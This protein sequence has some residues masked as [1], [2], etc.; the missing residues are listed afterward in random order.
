MRSLIILLQ[1]EI[2]L[3]LKVEPNDSKAITKQDYFS[4][5]SVS[6]PGMSQ[7]GPVG[8][9]PGMF[10]KDPDAKHKLDPS[11]KVFQANCVV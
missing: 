1:E 5:N 7:P 6:L 2:P 4:D 8:F 9:E 3:D 10:K 11:Q